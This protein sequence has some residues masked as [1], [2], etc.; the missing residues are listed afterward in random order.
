MSSLPRVNTQ[1]RLGRPAR[2]PEE[3]ILEAQSIRVPN[4]FG[5]GQGIVSLD[6]SHHLLVTQ[7]NIVVLLCTLQ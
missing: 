7:S 6:R 5:T 4:R 3:D 2:I 1:Q